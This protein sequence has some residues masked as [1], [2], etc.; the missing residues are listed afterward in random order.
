MTCKEISEFLG[1]SANTIKSRLSRARHRLKKEE[2]MIREALDHF[3][4]TPHLTE[5]IM[6]EIAR[7]KPIAPTSSKP[8]IPWAIAA[9][10]VIA[11][12]ILLGIGS[13]QY[14]IRFQQP[15]SFD[16]SSEM[17]VDLIEAPLVLNLVSK[18]DARTQI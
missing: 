11:V 5:N 17:T 4:I 10:T 13:H 12:L 1:V 15:Y 6:R 7:I 9:S 2:P 3:Q 18:P 8:F 14:A 16:A